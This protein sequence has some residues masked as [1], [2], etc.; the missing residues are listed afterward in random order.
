MQVRRGEVEGEGGQGLVG[1]LLGECSEE[2][3][4]LRVAMGG[5]EKEETECR[6]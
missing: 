6:A 1:E 2:G 3:S 4:G 5:G